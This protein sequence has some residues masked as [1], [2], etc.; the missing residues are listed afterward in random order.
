MVKPQGAITLPRN[1]RGRSSISMLYQLKF[2]EY[3]QKAA[4]S[5]MG[6]EY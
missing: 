1:L 3:A 2:E 4:Y 6:V 5:L